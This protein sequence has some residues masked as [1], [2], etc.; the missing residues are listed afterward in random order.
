MKVKLML[1]NVVNEKGGTGN[2]IKSNIYKIEITS[3]RKDIKT[4]G[5]KAKE[6]FTKSFEM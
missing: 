2:N 5:R 6:I 1:E 3:L 4:Y